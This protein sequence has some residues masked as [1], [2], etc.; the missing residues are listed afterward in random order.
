MKYPSALII[1]VFRGTLLGDAWRT[2]C[3][4]EK[5]ALIYRQRPLDEDGQKCS[6]NRIMRT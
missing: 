4:D 3:A 5:L 6:E 2:S 1:L